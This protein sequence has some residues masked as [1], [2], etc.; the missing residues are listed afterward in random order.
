MAAGNVV[1]MDV[2]AVRDMSK[3]FGTISEVLTN[4]AKVLDV[5]SNILKTTA[6]IG[7]VGGAVVAQVID[8]IKPHIEDL[9]EKTEE[10]SNDLS[11]S[12]DAYERGDEQGATR[13]Y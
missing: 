4:V 6:F 2:P 1:Y 11:A 12:V 8:Q 10:L 7:N 13:F 3:S 9:A 5:L